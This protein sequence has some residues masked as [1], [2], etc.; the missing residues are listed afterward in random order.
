MMLLRNTFVFFFLQ[1][2]VQSGASIGECSMSK[3]IAH[4][5]M[6]IA[7]SPKNSLKKMSAPII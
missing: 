1:L 7:L 2:G 3:K 5:P 4:G 6:N